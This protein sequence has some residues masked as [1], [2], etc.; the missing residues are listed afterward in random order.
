MFLIFYLLE[1]IPFCRI[2]FANFKKGS[3]VF[4]LFCINV[5]K[6]LKTA[7]WTLGCLSAR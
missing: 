1:E 5:T 4:C 7:S 2:S 6:E 3:G